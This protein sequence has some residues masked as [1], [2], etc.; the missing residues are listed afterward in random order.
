VGFLTDSPLGDDN[1]LRGD[2]LLSE[3]G[4]FVR[5]DL[6]AEGR[7]AGD[8]E[9]A[10]FERGDVVAEAGR[11][12]GDLEVAREADLGGRPGDF[13]VGV[14]EATPEGAVAGMVEVRLFK[15]LLCRWASRRA[16]ISA[17]VIPASSTKKLSSSLS[18][19][20][21]AGAEEVEEAEEDRNMAS[22]AAT[23]SSSALGSVF[24]G[25][26]LP[27]FGVGV[28]FSQWV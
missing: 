19:L 14:F 4:D 12:A 11:D 15:S 5:G 17:Q 13:V 22:T 18:T 8:L 26:L 23:A 21:G 2:L 28:V 9:V 7:G 25:V 20:G 1:E 27:F 6:V 10:R 24:W 16:E 3:L